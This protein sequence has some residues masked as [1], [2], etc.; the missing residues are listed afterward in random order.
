VNAQVTLMRVF[1]FL[2]ALFVGFPLWANADEPG[3]EFLTPGNRVDAQ[4]R[5]MGDAPVAISGDWRLDLRNGDS[6]VI[7]FAAR[8]G[9]D[10][11]ACAQP[12]SSA[13]AWRIER[14]D[15]GFE[16]TLLDDTNTEV[17]R[18]ARGEAGYASDNATL[19][20]APH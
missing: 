4:G 10:A 20:P 7:T 8:G 13:S 6:C 5:R 17:W 15:S 18:G 9:A 3:E 12:V 2:A 1:V 19:L 16:L 11:S 14:N